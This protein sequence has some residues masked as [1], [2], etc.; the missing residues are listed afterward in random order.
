MVDKKGRNINYSIIKRSHFLLN[1]QNL[2]EKWAEYSYNK[3]KYKGVIFKGSNYSLRG[4]E[5][6]NDNAKVGGKVVIIS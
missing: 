2:K 4:D 5:R 3:K 1:N 6:K